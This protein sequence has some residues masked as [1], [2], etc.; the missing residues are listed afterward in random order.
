[1]SSG[2][3]PTSTLMPAS[4]PSE[5]IASHTWV[6]ASSR[7]RNL[8]GLLGCELSVLVFKVGLS[9]IVVSEMIP[10]LKHRLRLVTVGCPSWFVSLDDN[11]ALFARTSKGLDIPCAL[12]SVYRA[13]HRLL[14]SSADR[15]AGAAS[16]DK[17]NSTVTSI[18]QW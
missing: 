12:H 9:E 14:H 11:G 8:V 18:I 5:T 2:P 16:Y 15:A 1:M 3:S 13:V 10:S 4:F 6:S 17:H 7:F